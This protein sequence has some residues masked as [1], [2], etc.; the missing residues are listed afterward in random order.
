MMGEHMIIRD[1]FNSGNWEWEVDSQSY[2]HIGLKL[3]VLVHDQRIILDQQAHLEELKSSSLQELWI[4]RFI[5][6]FFSDCSRMFPVVK[7]VFDV[8]PKTLEEVIDT[9]YDVF[10]GRLDGMIINA[11]IYRQLRAK[12]FQNKRE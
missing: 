10:K 11:L 2:Y 8:S 6:R 1:L 5:E 9:F 3:T 7:Q 12:S 4:K